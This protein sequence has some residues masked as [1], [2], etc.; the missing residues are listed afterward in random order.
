MIGPPYEYAIRSH[1]RVGTD[2]RKVSPCVRPV[3]M[4]VAGGYVSDVMF[5]RLPLAAP[6]W[7]I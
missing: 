5:A 2:L 1:H 4:R 6:V 7:P 3:F